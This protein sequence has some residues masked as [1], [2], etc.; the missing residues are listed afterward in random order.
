MFYIWCICEVLWAYFYWINTVHHLINGL[1]M[2]EQKRL[3][4]GSCLSY[5]GV[6]PLQTV[7]M[8]LLSFL[9]SWHWHHI[10]NT[11]I[12]I[13]ASLPAWAET[14]RLWI[15]G[16]SVCMC[17]LCRQV[18]W[19]LLWLIVPWFCVSALLLDSV[20]WHNKGCWLKQKMLSINNCS[21]DLDMWPL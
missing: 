2:R 5:S 16:Y 21:I 20:S 17:D 6:W 9:V 3:S 10:I 4:V 15:I 1:E 11:N 14:K 19:H 13:M 12:S 8:M 7:N 18:A